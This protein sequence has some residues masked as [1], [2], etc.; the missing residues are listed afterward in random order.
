MISSPLSFVETLCEQAQERLDQND[1]DG[2]ESLSSEAV[3]R[4]PGCNRAHQMMTKIAL[5]RGDLTQAKNRLAMWRDL[6]VDNAFGH[7]G[8]L[9]E[10]L[11]DINSAAD[12][13]TAHLSQHPDDVPSL[14]GLA[15]LRLDRNERG[16]AQ[17][18]LQ[19]V[20][21]LAPDHIEGLTELARLYEEDG[22]LGLSAQLYDRILNIDPQN[23]DAR[24]AKHMLNTQLTAQL[25]DVVVPSENH[26]PQ[27]MLSL[28][29]GRTD[30]YARQWIDGDGKTGYVP[31]REPLTESVMQAHVRGDVTVGVY[32]VGQ[33]GTVR[34]LAIDLD[35][36]K[37]ALEQARENPVM[38]EAMKT[39]VLKD[40]RRLC[41]G[42]AA[43][44]L[45]VVLEDSGHKGCHVWL[46][47]AEPVRA[48]HARKF[49]QAFVKR[50]GPPSEHV[51]WEI[52]PKQDDVSEGELG[53][54]IKLPLGIHKKTGQRG[55]FVD[56]EGQPIAKQ[57]E[58]LKRIQPISL[59]DF[60]E[61]VARLT[62]RETGSVAPL[63]KEDLA[64]QF[65]E[66]KPILSGCAVA[67]ALC[68][69]AF[70]THHLTHS[71]RHV[72][73]CVFGHLGEQGHAFLHAV[74]GACSDYNRD[75]TQYHLNQLRPSPIG[76]PR[77]RRYLPD[78]TE[79]VSCCCEFKLPEGGYPSPVL[80][81]D[82]AFT[83]NMGRID[84]TTDSKVVDQY[85]TLRQQ[86]AQVMAELEKTEQTVRALLTE[87]KGQ[88][89]TATWIIEQTP[90][91]KL[92]IGVREV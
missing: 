4:D 52:F 22:L 45:P 38:K 34:F 30:V 63:Q 12:I 23:A 31:V 70:S 15:M 69:K 54:L 72:L 92:Q 44:K 65:P 5:Q 55:V 6:P 53:N 35:I 18:L 49:A 90:D 81:I 1:L 9:A 25:P 51:Q 87:R 29:A 61:A 41:A 36:Q 21:H 13:Y 19:R 10:D 43:L 66:L 16:L 47:F 78:L 3:A 48:V 28:F 79:T 56:I 60:K 80:H 67:R 32:P 82:G 57:G 2:A 73:K 14:F 26:I 84:R 42:F 40:V 91:G 27:R 62:G 89:K 39:Q 7:W 76:C 8:V 83:E 33:D 86:A 20:I 68:E 74:I 71:E 11:Q 37:V 46:F 59:S 75:T 50:F 77:I 85:V 88:L 58:V 24:A 17:E 64:E